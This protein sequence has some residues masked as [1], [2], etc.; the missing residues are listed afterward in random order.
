MVK[1]S[2]SSVNLSRKRVGVLGGTFNPPHLGHLRMAEEL[3]HDY[4]LDEIVF[5]PSYIPP[6]KSREGV[7]QASSRLEMTR[8]SC[9]NNDRFSVSS[10]EIEAR[11]PSYTV[12]TLESF[13]R[14]S[15]AEI[16]FILGTD[17][18]R[19]I[20]T[21]KQ[22]DRLFAL[23]HFLVV[24]R[25][26]ISFAHA[27]EHVPCAVLK[28][29]QKKDGHFL[30]VSGKTLIPSVIEGLNISSTKIREMVKSGKSI[31]YLVTDAVNTYILQRGLYIN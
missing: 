9:E 21:W 24:T 23:A 6:H 5:I 30:H 15:P 18:L 17:S 28:A 13:A 11:G 4:H 14:A 2:P 10:F 16:F 26:G 27:W 8:I 7:A 22:Y 3:A 25:P 31:R 29:F 19:E 1:T 20:A 12:Y